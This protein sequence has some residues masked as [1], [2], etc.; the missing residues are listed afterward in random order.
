VTHDIAIIALI[1][2]G[3]ALMAELGMQ[4]ARLAVAAVREIAEGWR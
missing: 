4:G 2:L 3:A 1:V